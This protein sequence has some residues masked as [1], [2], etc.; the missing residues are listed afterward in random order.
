MKLRF[1]IRARI[2]E[3]F[4]LYA[5]ALDSGRVGC[6]NSV[7]PANSTVRSCDSRANRLSAPH[8]LET[9]LVELRRRLSYSFLRSA[10]ISL[11]ART[12][13][14]APPSMKPVGCVNWSCLQIGCFVGCGRIYAPHRH[15]TSRSSER[16]DSNVAVANGADIRAG[17]E[18]ACGFSAS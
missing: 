9:W 8:R 7:S 15:G 11:A 3:W 13:S 1:D 18:P 6:A 2:R 5:V 14:E 16:A 10:R 12:P 4:L 17:A